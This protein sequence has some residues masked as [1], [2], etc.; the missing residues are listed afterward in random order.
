MT[1]HIEPCECV[2]RLLRAVSDGRAACPKHKI[3]AEKVDG[4]IAASSRPFPIE[5]PSLRQS[6][7]NPLAQLLVDQ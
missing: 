6:P 3:W 4:L 2:V 7:A 5:W 1:D